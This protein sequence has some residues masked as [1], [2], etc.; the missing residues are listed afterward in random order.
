MRPSPSLLVLFMFVVYAIG[1]F[2]GGFYY[3]GKANE[4]QRVTTNAA[5]SLIAESSTNGMRGLGSKGSKKSK[6]AKSATCTPNGGGSSGGS[7]APNNDCGLCCPCVDCAGT[8]TNN[9]LCGAGN[10]FTCACPASIV[11]C[12]PAP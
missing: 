2:I 1:C 8:P 6:S 10:S 9:Q 11:I 7:T 4:D 5:A 3:G 12:A